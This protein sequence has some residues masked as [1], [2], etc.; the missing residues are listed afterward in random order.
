MQL[1]KLLLQLLPKR[2]LGL[3][4]GLLFAPLLFVLLSQ[5]ASLVLERFSSVLALIGVVV[6]LRWL[7]RRLV[8][9]RQ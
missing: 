1:P 2:M 6:L 4:L 7:W 8:R 9:Q 5:A 3:L